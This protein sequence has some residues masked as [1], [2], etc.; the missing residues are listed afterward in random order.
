MNLPALMTRAYE[1]ALNSHDPSTQ[2]GSL[3]VWMGEVVAEGWNHIPDLKGEHLAK[4]LADRDLKYPRVIHGE[5]DVI[6]NAARHGVRTEGLT[7]V[8]PWA[9]CCNC[10]VV[11]MRAGIGKLIVHAPRMRKGHPLGW[12][13]QVDE[14]WLRM[15]NAGIVCEMLDV[16]LPDAPAIRVAEQLWQP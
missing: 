9:A 4:V 16:P 2:N 14:A 1:V 12:V 6:A 5:V 10:A 15:Q 13:P 8:A 11:M 7:I 3:L